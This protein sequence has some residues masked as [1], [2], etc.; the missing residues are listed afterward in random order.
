MQNFLDSPGAGKNRET[1]PERIFN[2]VSPLPEQNHPPS[3]VGPYPIQNTSKD[4]PEKNRLPH[5]SIP[6]RTPN[7]RQGHERS[8]HSIDEMEDE[9]STVKHQIAQAS[10]NKKIRQRN[11]DSNPDHNTRQ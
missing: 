9:A 7:Q 4:I 3:H 2:P 1:H 8:N 5:S 10:R 11:I 6:N